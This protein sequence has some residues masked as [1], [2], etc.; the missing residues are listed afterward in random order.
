MQLSEY[1]LAGVRKWC[2]TL[3]KN[4]VCSRRNQA[5]L[6][7]GQRLGQLAY[8][9]TLGEARVMLE[10]LLLLLNT[11]EERG[12]PLREA[13][14]VRRKVAAFLHAVNSAESRDGAHVKDLVSS[15]VEGTTSAGQV[16]GAPSKVSLYAFGL[17]PFL[18]G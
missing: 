13:A 8:P 11:C 14:Q 15:L 9:E 7:V 4:L 6:E 1:I 2:V 5:R 3:V 18:V 17:Q 16:L 10:N 12:T